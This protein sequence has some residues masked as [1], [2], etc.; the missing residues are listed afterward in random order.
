[1]ANAQ[2]RNSFGVMETLTA[3]VLP[4]AV[5]VRLDDDDNVPV[6]RATFLGVREGVELALV[7]V[8][9]LLR[10]PPVAP[11]MQLLRVFHQASSNAGRKG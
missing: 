11:V 3:F 2:W 9:A 7:L 1:M 8:I 6:L 10:V 5:V 4:D